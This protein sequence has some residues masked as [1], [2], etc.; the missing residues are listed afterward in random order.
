MSNPRRRTRR[1]PA[2][3]TAVEIATAILSALEP[4]FG[5]RVLRVDR[6]VHLD[7]S[8]AVFV[9]FANVPAGSGQLATLNAPSST[10]IAI[11]DVKKYGPS[12]WRRDQPAPDAIMARAISSRGPKM[13]AK[14]G[15]PRQVVDHVLKFFEQNRATLLAL[16]PTSSGF[17]PGRD[18]TTK[19]KKTV[20]P[21]GTRRDPTRA[22]TVEGV[23]AHVAR[24]YARHDLSPFELK[25]DY[26]MTPSQAYDVWTSASEAYGPRGRGERWLAK[27]IEA[28]LRAPARDLASVGTRVKRFVGRQVGEGRKILGYRPKKTLPSQADVIRRARSDAEIADVVR[29]IQAIRP[30]DASEAKAA[31][32]LTDD[33]AIAERY[34]KLIP[35]VDEDLR[36]RRDVGS[37][38]RRQLAEG[39]KILA[40]RPKPYPSQAGAMRRARSDSELWSYIDAIEK[41]RGLSDDEYRAMG[42][43]HQVPG[44]VTDRA[45]I[46]HVRMPDGS[47][48][49]LT[50]AQVAAIERRLERKEERGGAP[51]STLALI[52]ER[53][54]SDRP[55]PGIIASG[56]PSRDRGARA[57][58]DP[59][60]KKVAYCT[61]CGRPVR[62]NKRGY[63]VKHGATKMKRRRY[64]AGFAGEYCPGYVVEYR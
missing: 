54:Y 14:T 21:K 23:A 13:R 43:V 55:E 17:H 33:A 58:R 8:D 50:A 39:K 25:R 53:R 19:R 49:R 56:L 47:Q 1:D 12:A 41:R 11:T 34:R 30:L 46:P 2:R 62:V 59:E 38:I 36:S 26:G 61:T 40:H 52:R 4:A 24:E 7:D 18:R 27:R 51:S 48:R 28:A 15:T 45:P 44:Y 42:Q 32:A 3:P 37:F 35:A 60:V 6:G 5:G 64:Q 22:R 29:R 57:R 16:A 63:S 31:Y 10:T 9:S 20:R